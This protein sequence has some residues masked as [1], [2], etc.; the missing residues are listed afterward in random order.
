[1]MTLNHQFI[2][3]NDKFS[4]WKRLNNFKNKPLFW[5]FII[6]VGYVIGV[7]WSNSFF[8]SE[9]NFD[10]YVYLQLGIIVAI[11]YFCILSFMIFI[12]RNTKDDVIS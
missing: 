8:S 5:V 10:S 1:M 4:T 2:L 9:N 3:Y 12:N 11:V 6:V 7:I